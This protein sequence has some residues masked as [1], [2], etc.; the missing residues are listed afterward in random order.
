[1]NE[2]PFSL[3]CVV[4]DNF[5]GKGTFGEYDAATLDM[6]VVTAAALCLFNG[7]ADLF[8]QVCILLCDV[9]HLCLVSLVG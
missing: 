6:S 3:L 9:S 5:A 4:A 7:F 1:M 2:P 8:G